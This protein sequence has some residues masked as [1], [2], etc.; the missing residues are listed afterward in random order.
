ML[1]GHYTTQKCG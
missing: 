1:K